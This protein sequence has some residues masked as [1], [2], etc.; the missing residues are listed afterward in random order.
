M[1]GTEQ[2]THVVVVARV[3]IG[4]ADD[5][6]DGAAC[7]HPFEDTAEQFYLVWLLT[8]CGDTALSGTTPIEF[9]LDECQVDGNACRHTVHHSANG[10]AVALAEGGQPEYLSEGVQFYRVFVSTFY[11]YQ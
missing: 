8:G 7:R 5:K 4:V 11:C 2:V 10:L 6:T 3:L 9:L 1:R